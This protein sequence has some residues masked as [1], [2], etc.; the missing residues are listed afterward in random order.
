[1][2]PSPISLPLFSLLTLLFLF[3]CRPKDQFIVSQAGRNAGILCIP[4]LVEEDLIPSMSNCT[5]HT[6]EPPYLVVDYSP[7]ELW[8]CWPTVTS[9]QGYEY[10]YSEFTDGIFGYAVQDLCTDSVRLAYKSI[11][12]DTVI[13]T[14]VVYPE[15]ILKT[16]YRYL[17]HL[18]EYRFTNRISLDSLQQAQVTDIYWASTGCFYSSR[19][20]YQIYLDE[21]KTWCLN[22]LAASSLKRDSSHY[23]SEEKRHEILSA[24]AE[25]VRS[26]DTTGSTTF[27]SVWIKVGNKIIHLTSDQHELGPLYGMLRQFPT[28]EALDRSL[29]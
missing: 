20:R 18:V 22:T 12:G 4:E 21:S 19:S 10:E 25:A 6:L 11:F 23:L 16:N 2:K 1:M 24:V 5:D 3:S 26:S 27:D 9:P 29:E 28:A 13:L 7:S 17:S 15:S 8:Y 14:N